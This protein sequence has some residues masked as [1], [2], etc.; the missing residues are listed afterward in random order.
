MLPLVLP[1]TSHGTGIPVI[2]LATHSKVAIGLKNRGRSG[3]WGWSYSPCLVTNSDRPWLG[4]GARVD[5]EARSESPMAQILGLVGWS[6]NA[7]GVSGWFSHD[8]LLKKSPNSG[9]IGHWF[10]IE[11]SLCGLT[12]GPTIGQLRQ[13]SAWL[14][15]WKTVVFTSVWGSGRSMLFLDLEGNPWS[16][17]KHVSVKFRLSNAY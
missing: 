10:G 5:R 14:Y 11:V 6:F 2:P 16:K 17:I 15:R 4:G 9:R 13:S 1:W 12:P 3:V 8:F 7:T